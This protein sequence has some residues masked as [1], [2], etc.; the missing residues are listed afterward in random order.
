[1][2]RLF[3]AVALVAMVA[4]SA[5][6]GKTADEVRIYLNPGHG[7][8]GPNNRPCN[9]IGRP[10]Y[11]S[12]DP[13]TTGFYESNTNL[14]KVLSLL[15][16]LVDAGVPFDR[17]LNQTNDNPAR[18]GAALDLSQHIVM[19]HVKVGPYPYTGEADDDDNAY[20]RPLSE[21]REEVEANNFDIFIS[22]HSNAASEGATTN[23]PLFLYRG[24][25]AE[26]SVA[27]SKEIAAH[28]WPYSYSNAHMNWTHY[29]AS[30]NIR[31]DVSFY[32][33][34]R[35]VTNNGKS[36]TGYLGVLLHGVPGF[37][38][39]GY[40]HTYQPARQRA[41]NFD[42]DRHEGRL[43]ARGLV[44]YMGWK[45]QTTGEIYG[46]VRD[47]HEKFSDALYSPIAR[48]NDVYKPLN[49]A[50]VDLYKDGAKVASYT[51]DNDYNG[52]F[53]FSG[54][55]PGTYSL[56]YS[57]EGYKPATEE[58]TATFEVKANET[59]YPA[60]FL[61]SESYVPDEIVY[62]NYP[63]E[64]EG[65]P[66]F[67]LASE[68]NTAA[69]ETNT[70]LSEQLTG[71][72]IRRQI[73]RNGVLYVLALD[74]AK[75]P[76]I[77]TLDIAT[78]TTSTISTEGTT[79]GENRS[80]K[81][82]DIAF[83]AD[84]VL[85]A[86]S[87]GKNQYSDDVANGDGEVRGYVNVYK[88]ENSAE[89]VPTGT[90]ALWFSDLH[91][92]NFNRAYAGNTIAYSGDSQNGSLMMT[93]ET[94]GSAQSLRFSEFSIAD[95]AKVS[96]IHM[97]K[98]ISADSNWT[99]AKLGADYSLIVSPRDEEQ[100]IVD[101][102]NTNPTEWHI[103]A[104]GADVPVV[105]AMS[106]VLLNAAANGAS[107][108]KYAG[109]SL[110][111]APIVAD[112]KASGV[113]L[114]DITDG[115]NAAKVITT[116]S[117]VDPIDAAVV[118]AAGRAVYTKNNEDAITA[119]NIELYLV[120]DGRVTTFATAGVEQ[121]VF[122]GEY[123]YGLQTQDNGTTTTLSFNLSG[124]ATD[125]K[126]VIT[127][128]ENVE[129]VINLGALEEG[130]NSTV[131]ENAELG[132]GTFNWKV[133]VDAQTIPG[134]SK[135]AS[136][137]F[138]RTRGVAVDKSGSS[139]YQGS[140]YVG[141]VT[142]DANHACGVYRLDKDF[143]ITTETI[144]ADEFVA[145]H[146]ASPFRLDVLPDG[147]VL[148]CDWSDAHSG[149]HAINPND[150][151]VSQLF[152]GERQS[153][154]GAFIYNG[155]TIGGSTTCATVVGKGADT[156]LYVF[157]EDLGNVIS[158]YDIGTANK[159][160][161]APNAT[162]AEASAKLLNTNVDL[163]VTE[164]GIWAAQSRGA[165]NNNTG[166]PSFVYSDLEGNMILN[167]GTLSDIVTSSR[168]GVVV[169]RDNNILVLS[170]YTG[171]IQ[172]YDITWDGNTPT[173]TPK[174]TFTSGGTMPEQIEFD[175]AENLLIAN[176]GCLEA[177]ALPGVTKQGV[178]EGPSFA[179]GNGGVVSA[180]D[181]KKVVVFPNPAV[182]V[183]N[184]KSNAAIT[185]VAVFAAS[186]AAVSANAS[187]EGNAA[188]LNV[189]GLASGIYFVKINGNQVVRFIK[190]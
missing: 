107:C 169:N 95:G 157:N 40:F 29:S 89:G 138:A 80:L 47:L 152:A 190:K 166:A 144:G 142:G 6:A 109:R 150:L 94:T 101:G 145:S 2:K 159:I 69:S 26:A 182:D 46:I 123:A 48:T 21:I 122:K 183:L 75:E 126:V 79:L 51:T 83:T 66:L 13:D 162:F 132:T 105:G 71:K 63:D 5:M 174:Y 134:V 70:A 16:G 78:G 113:K 128:S 90:P 172:V 181:G 11:T 31:G 161:F 153:T 50:V 22:V 91:S 92:G 14:R 34:S 30:T 160:D 28:I 98:N 180:V 119:A 33:S 151:S 115:L 62:V 1:M 99:V 110:M 88:W 44:D 114:F 17:T 73:V 19:S 178:T 187:I 124:N 118:S 104:K 129:K 120:C 188:T 25:D 170:G 43:Y 149:I 171:D 141:V 52:A 155:A 68:Y 74:E 177:Y 42:V 102:S 140:I 49:G 148:A 173:L 185:D 37:L 81:I 125:V 96:V 15:D 87:Y 67:G 9:T 135:I 156:Q 56:Q 167:G 117:T 100:Y 176:N 158:R 24:T 53:V 18:V 175:L 179:I 103:A 41:M 65:N 143:N 59:V 38:V 165:G 39:E 116:N 146:T 111:V 108:F 133:V 164:T 23:Y 82:S 168:S 147:T 45:A 154:D 106:E 64:I 112:G 130:A 7:S 8:W 61:E 27:G 60:A 32:N 55:E 163:A 58:Y 10:A 3:T 189:S 77:Y 136:V 121:P 137:P 131:V 184:V 20:N 4:A 86:C 35:T 84:N 127:D 139:A 186:G 76:Y 54:L 72:T 93:F 12:A 57:A 85:V 36:Y 97:N